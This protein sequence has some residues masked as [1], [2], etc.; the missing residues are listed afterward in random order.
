MRRYSAAWILNDEQISQRIE[1]PEYLKLLKKAFRDWSAA[2]SEEKR[3][4]VRNL[5]T[6]AAVH[7][8]CSDDVVRMFIVWIERYSENHFAV[9]K[10]IYKNVGCTR[11]EIWAAVHGQKVR[12]DSAE[13][14][15]FKL[16]IHEFTTG[17]VIRQHRETDYAGN[18]LKISPR[19]ARR[20]TSHTMK[21]AFDDEKEYELTELGNQFVRYTM[22][23]VMPR[24]GATEPTFL[25]SKTDA[26]KSVIQKI[27]YF[28]RSAKSARECQ[29]SGLSDGEGKRL[30]EDFEK[31]ASEIAGSLVLDLPVLD[32]AKAYTTDKQI[33]VDARHVPGRMVFDRGRPV[34]IDATEITFH[35]PFT[36]D[37]SIFDLQPTTYNMNPPVADVDENKSELLIVQHAFD[38]ATPV[39]AQYERTLQEIKQHL[40]WL[41]PAAG[42]SE[43]M[44]QAARAE[45][46]KRK[47]ADETH[48]KIVGS[49]GLP[50]RPS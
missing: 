23:N 27:R 4:L 34:L 48:N 31:L 13:A 2:E 38:E 30:S 21:S 17:H 40:E 15:L 33:K 35:I 41:R 22:E 1:S 45:L 16:I 39:R 49:V 20:N 7:K 32:D 12:E 3:I 11:A 5:L 18:F 50:R 26:T 9:L 47:Q 37:A 43:G 24:I 19:A 8:I 25:R 29:K 10:F 42:Q 44:K 6:N 36:G 14:D 28:Q 46:T